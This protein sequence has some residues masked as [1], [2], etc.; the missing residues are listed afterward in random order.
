MIRRIIHCSGLFGGRQIQMESYSVCQL[1][2]DMRFE[3]FL[4]IRSCEK[5]KDSK[6]NDYVDLNLTDRTGEINCKI[7]NWDPEAEIP[8]SGQPL[9]VRGTV[10]EYNGRLQLRVEKW[11]L[12]TPEDPV[13]MNAL[14]PCAPRKPQEMNREIEETIDSFRDED[15]KKLVR[16]MLKIAGSRLDW[17]PA[18]QRMHHA[19]RS[20]LL[21]HTTDMLRLAK[22]LLEIYPWLN[23]DL[24]L[25]GVIIHDLGKIDEMKSD[26]AGNVADYT[27][28]GQLLGHLVRGITNLNRAAEEAGVSGECVVLLEHMLLSHHGESEY[29]SPKPP[30]FSEAEAL[31]WIDIMDA[32]MNT[33]KSVTD[34]TPPGAFSEKIFSL[35]RRVYHPL[36][37]EEAGTKDTE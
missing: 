20:G 31:H 21:H 13:D 24:L 6:G 8:E 29:G 36:Y 19:E 5:R 4:L 10:Q 28:D 30:M 15:L 37:P 26:P 16:G 3:G 35:D 33:M 17:F 11:R 18:A 23:R 22:A 32:R 1:Q 7:W 25:A 9:K 14:V 2:R 34:R 27:R 12:S